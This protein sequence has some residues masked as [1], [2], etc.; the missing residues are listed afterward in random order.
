[1]CARSLEELSPE[2]IKNTEYDVQVSDGPEVQSK[3]YRLGYVLEYLLHQEVDK[4]L[5]S[6]RWR[7]GSPRCTSPVFLHLVPKSREIPQEYLKNNLRWLS[8]ETSGGKKT[9]EDL[10]NL[11][12]QF[13]SVRLV[14]D[15]R[16]VNDRTML[17]CVGDGGR[18]RVQEVL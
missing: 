9:L 3:P 18:S 6:G 5:K 14:N 16:R 12:R 10:A 15:Y 11:I 1:I 8:P 17:G 7:R 2:G 13:Y 4:Y